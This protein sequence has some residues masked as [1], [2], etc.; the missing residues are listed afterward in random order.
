[1]NA[2]ATVTLNPSLD[3]P[4]DLPGLRLGETNRCRSST[5]DPGGKGIN[6]SRVIHRLG[7]ETV[8]YGFVGGLTGALLRARLDEERVTHDFDDVEGLTRFDVMIYERA[9]GRRTRL[10]AEGP[11]VAP[12]HVAALQARLCAIGAGRIVTLGGSAPPG[13]AP[14]IYRDL[15]TWLNARGVR[16]IVDV[17]GEA[18]ASVLQAHPALIKPNEEEAAEVAGRALHGDDEML[19][20]AIELRARGAACVVISQ[21]ERGALGVDAEGAW[22]IEVPSVTV[23]STIGSGDSMVGAMALALERGATFPDALRL[24]AAAGTATAST[25]ERNLCSSVDVERLVRQVIVRP[26]RYWSGTNGS[27]P[28]SASAASHAQRG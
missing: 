6:A 7:G 12:Q 3:V 25:P 27:P 2:I 16:C 18:L 11:I 14:T 1:M 24:G 23:S 17:S 20:A 4:V 9:V 8:A 22:K 15:V 13:I 21:G 5:I 26:L 28:P 10:L 19:E